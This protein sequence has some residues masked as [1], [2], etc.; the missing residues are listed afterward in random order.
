MAP[1]TP[2]LIG[3]VRRALV[4]LEAVAEHGEITAKRLS[5]ETR[6]PLP[7]TYHLLR[8]LVHDGYLRRERGT[9]RLGPAVPR[10]S[11]RGPGPGPALRLAEW[12]GV[13]RDELGAPVYYA[14]LADGEVRVVASAESPEHRAVEEW[15]DFRTSAHAHALGQCLLAQLSPEDRRTYLARRPVVR[16]T[17][18]T[19]RDEEGLLR[20]LAGVRRGAPVLE[21]EEYALG[22]VCAAVPITVG[23]VHSAVGFSLPVE[24]R[25][26][27][28]PTAELLRERLERALSTHAFTMLG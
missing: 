2:T 27:L 18:R 12:L 8:T 3:S 9:F 15:A 28:G 20:R 7:T 24:E 6:L 23:G 13:L 11:G 10:L 25:A 4:L 17:P 19:V 14:H 22:T 5:R 1:S 16:L 21:R 26:R